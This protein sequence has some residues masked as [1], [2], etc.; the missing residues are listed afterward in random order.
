MNACVKMFIE[1]AKKEDLQSIL[2]LQYLAYQS[3]AKLFG[4]PDIPPLRQTLAELEREYQ[5]GIVL[6]AADENNVIIGSVRA[7]RDKST[8]YINK[9]M[10]HPEWQGQGIG[11]KLLLTM[12]NTFPKRRYELFT[13]SKSIKNIELYKKLGYKIF[14]EKQMDEELK[15]VYF[16]KSA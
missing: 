9:L 7:Y 6:K 13:S 8:V 1:K 11:T 12:E 16:E 3:E 14:S 15:F 4:N 10:V 5:R 2:A